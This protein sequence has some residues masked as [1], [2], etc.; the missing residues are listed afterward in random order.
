MASLFGVLPSDSTVSRLRLHDGRKNGIIRVDPV[1]F[2]AHPRAWASGQKKLPPPL[3][4]K[5]TKT[6]KKAG[7]YGAVKLT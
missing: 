4:E 3:T 5:S 6:G 7:K 2:L 1:Y